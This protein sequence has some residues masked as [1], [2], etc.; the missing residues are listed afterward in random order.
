[1]SSRLPA[2]RWA[3]LIAWT[4]AV[5]TWG[6]VAIGYQEYDAAVLAADV[7]AAPPDPFPVTTTTIALAPVPTLP[8]EGLVVLTYTAVPPPPP[9]VIVRRVVVAGPSRAPAS[10]PVKSSG[11]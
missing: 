11:S 3:S 10:K 6:A 5:V 9:E 2:P 8:E 1:M 4:A 7:S